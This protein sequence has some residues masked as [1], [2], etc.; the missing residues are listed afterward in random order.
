MTNAV[1]LADKVRD[2]IE[3]LLVNAAALETRGD[4]TMA[5]EIREDVSVIAAEADRMGAG[6]GEVRG[7]AEEARRALGFLAC[8]DCHRAG[9]DRCEHKAAISAL[10]R[11]LLALPDAPPATETDARPML[12][13]WRNEAGDFWARCFDPEIPGDGYAATAS[14]GAWYV[15]PRGAAA[16]LASGTAPNLAT[17]KVAADLAADRW[18]RLPAT[19]AAPD[20]GRGERVGDDT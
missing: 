16:P 11:A 19:P 10:A 4:G 5:A 2:A 9:L 6:A 20:L 7:M 13:A 14:G 12:T 17:A 1:T 3:S 8:S 18:Y 15:F